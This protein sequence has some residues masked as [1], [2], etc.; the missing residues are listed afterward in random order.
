METENLARR[1]RSFAR[2]RSTHE[3]KR[4][5]GLVV[6]CDRGQ[7]V[8]V[9]VCVCGVEIFLAVLSPH[10]KNDYVGKDSA[11]PSQLELRRLEGRRRQVCTEGR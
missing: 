5:R 7:L 4:M 6:L 2:M 9:C 10:V 1:Q 3:E 8:C 11:T